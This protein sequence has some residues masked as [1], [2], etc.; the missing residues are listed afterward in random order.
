MDRPWAAVQD[1]LKECARVST[2]A[3][4]PQ[5]LIDDVD[6]VQVL[7][8]Q[9]AALN[10]E[11]LREVDAQ[12]IPAR[13]GAANTT[14]W[15]RDRY[16][17]SAHTA[18]QQ[19]RLAAAL[20]PRIPET[21][22]ALVDGSINVEQA[23]L[24]A[25]AVPTLPGQYQAD[26]EK[27]LIDQCAHLGPRESGW[28]AER[29][30]DQIA[31]E[32]AEQRAAERLAR[33]EERAYADR[34]FNL[35]DL[36]GDARVRFSGWLDRES[37]AVVRAAIDPLCAPRSN[38]NGAGPRDSDARDW[39]ARGSGLRSPNPRT[40]DPRDSGPCDSGPHDSGP[41]DSDPRTPG[42]RRADALVEVC[43]LALACRDLPDNAEQQPRRNNYH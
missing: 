18:S 2:W 35:T 20:D 3:R 15:I 1:A 29:L 41:R 36:H 16:R 30:L 28:L 6:W 37:A 9:L 4:S 39:D 14:A 42:Q 38:P 17:L 25:K 27:F 31:P 24:I 34:C 23:Q 11:L 19:V 5:E 10:L 12:G 21:A 13:L 26:G 40:A 33:S 7:S 8:C 32:V 43:R 22:A